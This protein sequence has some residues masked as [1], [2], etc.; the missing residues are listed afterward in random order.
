MSQNDDHNEDGLLPGPA[1]D[2]AA[3]D[4]NPTPVLNI[5][6]PGTVKMAKF[7]G[8]TP[9]RSYINQFNRV[10]MMN[11]WTDKNAYLWIHLDGDALHYLEEL[12]RSTE[13]TFE[14]IC[15]VLDTRFSAGRLSNL[16]KAELLGR[17]RQQGES[18]SQF[19]QSIRQL[20]NGAYP[21]FPTD[22]KEELA[23]EKFLDALNPELRRVIYQNN[24]TTLTAAIEEGLKLE[25]WGLVEQRKHGQRA[26]IRLCETEAE[27]T[28]HVRMLKD[29]AQKVES[30]NDNRNRE[31]N[32]RKTIVCFYCEKKG[33]IA[34]DCYKRKREEAGQKKYTTAT[35]ATTAMICYRCGGKGH[36]SS[37]CATPAGNE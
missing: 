17:R 6:T 33:H 16:Q 3:A 30:L 26:A 24:P 21:N 35:P 32:D 10:S 7:N 4:A 23:I 20:V 22:A 29:L 19:G 28:E 8:S 25:A 14:E 18:L 12:P 9:W 5:M 11:G 2:A 34:R 27:D 31:N 13:M 37:E 36:R 1:D 15:D